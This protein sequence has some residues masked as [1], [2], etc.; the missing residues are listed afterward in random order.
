MTTTIDNNRILESR[1]VD[2]YTASYT[3]TQ[4]DVDS[5]FLSNTAT[6]TG[7][8][9]DGTTVVSKTSDDGDPS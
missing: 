5:K 6:F 7:I 3:I 1:S 4:D 8:D 9:P 2:T